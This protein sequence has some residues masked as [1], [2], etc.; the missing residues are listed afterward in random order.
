MFSER[1]C[2]HFSAQTDNC[3]AFPGL[4]VFQTHLLESG[5]DAVSSTVSSASFLTASADTAFLPVS[6]NQG[7]GVET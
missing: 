3:I 1:H 2:K 4:F 6:R 5:E 7:G